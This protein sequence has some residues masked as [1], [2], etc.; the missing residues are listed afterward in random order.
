MKFNNR[1][2]SNQRKGWY[3]QIEG[4]NYQIVHVEWTH[5]VQEMFDLDEAPANLT[6]GVESAALRVRGL[7]SKF[8]NVLVNVLAAPEPFDVEEAAVNAAT[9][10]VN[11]RSAQLLYNM[12]RAQPRWFLPTGEDVGFM[13]ESVSQPDDPAENFPIWLMHND[14]PHFII[15]NPFSFTIDSFKVHFLIRQYV[16]RTVGPTRPPGVHYITPIPYSRSFIA[17]F[18]D[19]P[20]I[21]QF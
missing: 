14:E 12:P 9:L 10:V 6:S 21:T 11:K 15:R 4:L 13:D 18:S 3:V 17:Q 1:E 20:K 7:Q 5:F 19:R 16:L 8:Y 2:D